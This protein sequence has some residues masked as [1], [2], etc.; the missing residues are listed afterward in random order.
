MLS[1]LENANVTCVN[2]LLKNPTL[3]NTFICSS[4]FTDSHLGM[5]LLKISNSTRMPVEMLLKID[6]IMNRE[7]YDKLIRGK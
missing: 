1:I 6:L 5:T 2:D 4:V 3:L 7:T